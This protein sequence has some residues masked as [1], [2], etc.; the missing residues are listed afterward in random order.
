[1][2]D[3]IEREFEGTF[4]ILVIMRS[5]G[6]NIKY[7]I[8]FLC[9]DQNYYAAATSSLKKLNLDDFTEGDDSAQSNNFS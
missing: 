8:V 6:Y 3:E 5:C 4:N 2:L 7:W 9:F 1:M